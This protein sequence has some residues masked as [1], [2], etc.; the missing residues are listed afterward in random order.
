MGRNTGGNIK[1][2][3][4]FDTRKK[5]EAGDALMT[6]L[7]KVNI[8]KSGL[9][10]ILHKCEIFQDTTKYKL[11]N[12]SPTGSYYGLDSTALIKKVN[13]VKSG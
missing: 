2:E 10:L 1:N 9:K 12:K 13:I 7:I 8:A 11:P 3:W 5:L 6:A 4:K